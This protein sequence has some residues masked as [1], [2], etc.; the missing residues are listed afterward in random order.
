MSL[1]YLQTAKILPDGSKQPPVRMVWF[2]LDT[3]TGTTTGATTESGFARQLG[4]TGVTRDDQGTLTVTAGTVSIHSLGGVTFN[5]GANA[6]I[7]LEPGDGAARDF[8]TIMFDLS[9]YT[10]GQS[11]MFGCEVVTPAGYAA[12]ST[13]SI[14]FA[15]IGSFAT[16]EGGG[17][18][19]GMASNERPTFFW[20]AVDAS[21]SGASI[22]NL[23]GVDAEESLQDDVRNVIIYE[24]KCMGANQFQARAHLS[25]VA[26]TTYSGAWSATVDLSDPA[27]SG[28]AAPGPASGSGLRLG[29]RKNGA[30]SD[31]RL[32]LGETLRNCWF[33]QF[34][35]TPRD[36]IAPAAAADMH[37]LR[38]V[39]PRTIRNYQE[40]AVDIEDD[41]DGNADQAFAPV[42]LGDMYIA[43]YPKRGITSQ[44]SFTIISETG[45]SK[46]SN[47]S[48]NI[49]TLNPYWVSTADYEGTER[50]AATPG[51]LKF[52]RTELSPGTVDAPMFL[53]S[54]YRTDVSNRNRCELAWRGD[55]VT[56]Q[57]GEVYWI[58]QRLYYNFDIDVGT[59]H[60]AVAQIFHGASG[61]GIN[62]FYTFTIYGD[63]I[64]VTLRSCDVVNMVKADQVAYNY[65]FPGLQATLKGTTFD[66]VIKALFH[67]DSSQSPFFQLWINGVQYVDHSSPVGYRGPALYEGVS[68]D[69]I[70]EMRF[71]NYPGAI[72][73]WT[74]DLPRDLYMGNCFVAKNVGNYTVEQ[75]RTALTA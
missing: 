19:F 17:Y 25:Y 67:W 56:I 68:Y 18:A 8:L 22:V 62:P 26:G 57:Y 41:P 15:T 4:V 35:S 50:A 49:D 46:G 1:R 37:V 55:N 69:I 58:A 59:Q 14:A 71:G 66:V 31:F 51:G 75:I 53:C 39:L 48:T 20:R 16:G 44:P 38:G 63:K 2:P 28:T 7:A 61:S 70:P 27:Q 64:L 10:E 65:S 54:S 60:V 45:T 30:T 12:A 29:A 73:T 24:L 34:S 72:E 32:Q 40:D 36:A 52:A 13:V 47:K 43:L 5:S 42:T 6:R 74:P 33:A 11:L 3:L 21:A 23:V 9:Q